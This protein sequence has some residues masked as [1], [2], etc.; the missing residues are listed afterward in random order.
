MDTSFF[1]HCRRGAVAVLFLLVAL[2]AWPAGAGWDRFEV[3]LWQNRG[4]AALAAARQLGV[5]AVMLP[6]Q[7]GAFDAAALRR[8]AAAIA[9][10][11]LGF[12]VENIA[13]DFYA[14]Y[15]RWQPDVAPDA[16]FDALRARHLRDPADAGVWRREPGLTDPLWRARIAARLRAHVATLAPWQPLYYSLGD[17]TGIA[18]LS[19]AWDFDQAPAALAAFRAWL[20]RRYG[21]LAALNREWGSDFPRWGA[22]LPRGTSAAIAAPADNLAPWGDFKAWM[23]ETFAAALGAG[24]TALHAADPA[25]RSAIE[26]AQIPG[27]GGYDYTRLVGAVDVM[28]IYEYADN[29]AIAAA[30]NPGLVLL[31]TSFGSG[32]AAERHRIWH[33][34]LLGTRGVILWDADGGIVGADGAP[35]RRGSALAPLFAALH[36]PAGTRWL[37]AR[38]LPG[39][40]G[41][42]YSPASERLRWLLDRK[43]GAVRGDPDWSTRDAAAELQ[44]TAPRRARRAALA[45]LTQRA[46]MPRV[47]SPA[48]LAAGVPAGV[49]VLLLAQALALSDGAVA[50]IGRFAAA[51]GVVLADVAPGRFDAD[52]RRRAAPPLDPALWRQVAF[53]MPPLAAALDRAGIAAPALLTRPDGAAVADVELRLRQEADG[54][55]LLALLP[56][57]AE[58]VVLTLPRPPAAVQDLLAGTPAQHGARLLLRLDPATP[59]LLALTPGGG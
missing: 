49:R 34:A 40:V 51:G 44:D 46:L 39:P 59:A 10:T 13:T 57:A 33:A 26:G 37:A 6:A 58:T 11:G 20:H 12:Y 23:D 21:S 1:H 15:H 31:T 14:A 17:E 48:T 16:R 43:A 35:G 30:L 3:I 38:P 41:I 56:A 22:V 2:A 36:G 47:L 52:G 5:T 9:A 42:L 8:A 53:D 7:R 19:A 24:T 32:D 55:T 18:D 28:E 25:A 54:T 50:A 4:P 29:I 27:W 45:V